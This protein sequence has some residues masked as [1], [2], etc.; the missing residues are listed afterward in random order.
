MEN[1]KQ[2]IQGFQEIINLEFN[3]KFDVK[4]NNRNYTIAFPLDE[5]PVIK[6]FN[7]NG[8]TIIIFFASMDKEYNI[9]HN[10]IFNLLEKEPGKFEAVIVNMNNRNNKFKIGREVL[11]EINDNELIGNEIVNTKRKYLVHALYDALSAK[12]ENFWSI[13]FSNFINTDNIT[14]ISIK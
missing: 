11:E 9:D 3:K 12:T 4:L 8:H 2:I 6:S 10:K 7:K 14:C 13:D 5:I 1:E